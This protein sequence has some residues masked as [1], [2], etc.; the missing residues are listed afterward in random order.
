MSAVAH[1]DVFFVKKRCPR[2]L[3]DEL[4]SHEKGAGCG[5]AGGC[6][7]KVAPLRETVQVKGKLDWDM[8]QDLR[9]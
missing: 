5:V 2:R 7:M 1:P 8:I 4:G 6:R 3:Q 9:G